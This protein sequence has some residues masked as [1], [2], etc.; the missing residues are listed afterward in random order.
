M[1]TRVIQDQPE[2]NGSGASGGTPHDGP[3]ERKRSVV[4]RIG[5]WSARN[6]KKAIVGWL[7]FVI[8]A[9][10]AGKSLGEEKIATADSFSG[11]SRTAERAADAAGLRPNSEIAFVQSDELTIEDPAF[12]AAI[13][14]VSARLS[15]VQ[16]VENVE[17]PLDGGGSVTED[18]HSALIDFEIAGDSIEAGERVAPTLAVVRAVQAANPDVVVEQFG[19]VSADDSIEETIQSDL[20]KAGMLSL[21]I[22]LIILTIAFGSLVAAGVPLLLGLSAVIGAM[23]LSALASQ[24]FPADDSV[25]AVI[26]LIGLAVGVDYSMFYLGANARS[27]PE[28]ATCTPRSRSPERRRAALC[29]L[30]A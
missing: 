23:G 7:V 22:T 13:E 9:F 26:L 8:A 27:G 25:A 15:K 4:A 12:V 1:S 6:R 24:L 3:P 28:G 30:R 16:Y 2:S 20:G 11:E 14:D 18:G 5:R 29:S 21:P 19:N 10:M 17:T